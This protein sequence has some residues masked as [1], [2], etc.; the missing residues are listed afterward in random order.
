MYA[1][2]SLISPAK[3]EVMLLT[4]IEYVVI[5]GTVSHTVSATPGGVYKFG[6]T[7]GPHIAIAGLPNS[8]RDAGENC[9]TLDDASLRYPR[10][11]KLILS[12]LLLVGKGRGK[13][14]V[15]DPG[16]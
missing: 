3:V 14:G 10:L 12:T 7:N 8:E 1:K 6:V 4:V 11:G 5:F 9:R 13:F 2:T 15:Y 16:K